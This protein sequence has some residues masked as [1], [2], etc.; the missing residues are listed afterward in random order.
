M[1]SYLASQ[2]AEKKAR[3]QNDKE[4]INQQAEMWSLDKQNWDLEEKR[5]KERIN[6]INADNAAFL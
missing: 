2:V 5:L 3:E 4:N 6:K 1:R